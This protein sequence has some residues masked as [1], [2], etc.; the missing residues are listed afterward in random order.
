MADLYGTDIDCVL[1]IGPTLALAGHAR[2]I[3]NA[4]ARRLSTPR[5]S[6]IYDSDYGYDVRLLLNAATT[7]SGVTVVQSNISRECVKDERIA[8]CDATYNYNAQLSSLT[9]GLQI[10]LADGTIFTLILGV[11][12]ATVTLLKVS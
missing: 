7:S 1:D 4:L 5:G 12:A 10:T 6:L 9:I 3:G 8:N 2:N 11:N